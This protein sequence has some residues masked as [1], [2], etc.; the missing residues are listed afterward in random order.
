MGNAAIVSEQLTL[1]SNSLWYSFFLYN[2]VLLWF[3]CLKIEKYT[4]SNENKVYSKG[5]VV[6][7][8]IKYYRL[9]ECSIFSPESVQIS[10]S[11]AVDRY[12]YLH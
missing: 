4:N 9:L 5:R 3:V 12:E 8:S 11:L 2:C 6:P 10:F 1:I 7:W